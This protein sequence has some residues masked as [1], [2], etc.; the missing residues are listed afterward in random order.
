MIAWT[1]SVRPQQE[2]SEMHFGHLHGH[3]SEAIIWFAKV[4]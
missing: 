2:L 4:R 1:S 3:A